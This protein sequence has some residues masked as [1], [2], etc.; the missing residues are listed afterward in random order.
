MHILLIMCIHL[1]HRM[2]ISI[3][4]TK[5]PMF[6]FVITNLPIYWMNSHSVKIIEIDSE[7]VAEK[8]LTVLDTPDTTCV[9][10]FLY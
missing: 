6:G 5:Y 9:Y 1:D 10:S 7:T 4:F 2:F 8:S 3:S